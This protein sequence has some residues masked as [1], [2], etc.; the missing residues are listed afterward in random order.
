MDYYN[1]DD[2]YEKNNNLIEGF[3][4]AKSKKCALKKHKINH[5]VSEQLENI[6]K[7]SSP[8][9][10][11]YNVSSQII[12]NTV[13]PNIPI[14]I[15][16][17]IP[18]V[19]NNLSYNKGYNTILPTISPQ[20]KPEINPS[21]KYEDLVNAIKSISPNQKSC[22]LNTIY[23]D[24]PCFM[25]KLNVLYNHTDNMMVDL[26]LLTSNL[27]TCSYVNK[28]ESSDSKTNLAAKKLESNK[29]ENLLDNVTKK[30]TMPKPETIKIINQPATILLTTGSRNPNENNL[31]MGLSREP[32][33]SESECK[34]KSKN[35]NSSSLT[36][37]IIVIVIIILLFFLIKI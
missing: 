30:L 15:Y 32:F 19:D 8:I 10:N 31:T 6:F 17:N 12:K 27:K 16:S 20:I 13:K 22:K 9:Q 23:V 33:S 1:F 3:S 26:T 5:S 35:N 37:L 2:D 14:P 7:S 24:L 36:W 4:S 11:E 18:K 28:V 34:N 25:D 21:D 29:P